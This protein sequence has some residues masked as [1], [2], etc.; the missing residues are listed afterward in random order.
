MDAIKGNIN[1]ILNG[2]KQ[3]IIPVYQRKYSWE[4]EQCQRLWDDI[5]EMQQKSRTGHFVGSIVNIAEQAMPTGIQKF[6][7]IDGQQRMTTLTL[8]LIALRDFGFE[9]IE[10]KS[11][12][13][14]EINGMCLQND[15]ATGEGKYKMLLTQTDKP[16]LI[17]LIERSP[18]DGIKASRIID[19]YKFFVGK[20]AEQKLSTQEIQEGVAKLQIVNITL[21]RAVDDAQL[22]FESLNST[23]M[24]LYQSDLIRNYILMGLEPGMQ[25]N[26]YEN[27][28]SLME[29]LFDYEKQTSLMDKF[30]RDYLSFSNGKIPN[31]SKVYEEFKHYHRYKY[32]RGVVEFCKELY[33][34]AKYYTNMYYA[35]SGDKQLDII[36]NDISQL[37][38]EVAFPFLLKVYA[39][40]ESNLIT[41]EEFIEILKCCESYVFRRAIAGI[42]TNSLNKTFMLMA[43]KINP[44]KYLNS[45]KAY[46]IMLDSYKLFPD[47]E[48]FKNDFII[49]DVYN[50][51]IRN[52]IFS[53]LEN[54]NNKA[55]INIE[56][57]TIEHIMPQNKNPL[58]EWKQSLGVNWQEVQ[59]TY[60]HSI[61]NLT[62]TAYNPE[63]SDYSFV[64]KLEMTGGF[65]ESALRINSYVVKQTT[66][67]ESTIIARAKELSNLAKKIWKY[68]ELT[69][70]E[71]TEFLPED[72]STSEYTLE[73]Y[74]YLSEDMLELFNILN[75]RILNI[76][77][78]V[79]RELKKLYIA[80][81][82]DTN[83]V[84][85]VPQKSRLRLS[86]NM[87]FHEINDPKGLCIDV[88]DKGRWGNGD[89]E[90]RL[91][92]VLQLDDV[93]DIIIQSYNKQID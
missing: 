12:N 88:T 80:Y 21:D 79:K 11:I 71:L 85:I 14:K 83:F 89:I 51:R 27:Y 15:Y 29:K 17:K 39:D 49:K 55:P 74:D 62:L 35:K 46:M 59:K 65:K 64:K 1:S 22:I 31:F 24:D 72:K 56:N 4:Q 70:N 86:I 63:M 13:P 66:W 69:E 6:M 10:D 19:N 25:H 75:I 20:I 37:Q 77:S 78:Y 76:S 34:Y 32:K 9:H 44:D 26:I 41:K 82:A 16:V 53:K 28:W 58:P 43:N 92:N 3:F 23:G 61:G 45:V 5:V 7:I 84:D 73:D 60:L 68:P 54:V 36:F 93:M 8:L 81:K 47:D 18:L 67:N 48:E 52:Y 50:M 90:V 42:P 30:F 57:Y 33:T 38:M 40:Y 87:K 91:E 2:S